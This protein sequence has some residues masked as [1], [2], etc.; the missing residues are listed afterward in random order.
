M[1]DGIVVMQRIVHD[2]MMSV[3]IFKQC[4]RW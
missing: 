3:L 4:T 1:V 2:L